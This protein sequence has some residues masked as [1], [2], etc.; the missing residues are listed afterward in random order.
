[1]SKPFLPYLWFL[2]PRTLK[3]ADG[4]TDS[5]LGKAVEVLASLLDDARQA[6]FDA[7]RAWLPATSNE[8]ALD[9]LGA[10]RL[11]HRMQGESDEDYQQRVMAAFDLHRQGGTEPG[12]VMAMVLMGFDWATV[13]EPRD[14]ITW[15]L[16][17]AVTLDGMTL[18][19]G[20]TRWAEFIVTLPAPPEGMTA[21]RLADVLRQVRTW[22]PAHTMLANLVL[23]AN[24]LLEDEVPDTEDEIAVAVT[25]P[26]ED[27]YAWPVVLLDGSHDLDST[28]D[29]D[30]GMDTLE[31][32][33]INL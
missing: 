32:E 21:E 5:E 26:S 24:E 15:H 30:Q 7:R 18:I 25:A 33:V 1:V 4:T 17:G 19:G 16:D 11:I 8:E 12:M 31:L 22:K 2:L 10:D 28:W 29:L 3:P 23:S 27:L 14:P 20:R 13:D 9:I 6:V